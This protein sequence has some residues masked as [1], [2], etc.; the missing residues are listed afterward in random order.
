MAGGCPRRE[1]D[2]PKS[3]ISSAGRQRAKRLNFNLP[4]G[5]VAVQKMWAEK[6]EIGPFKTA[7][8]TAGYE[9]TTGTKAGVWVL[10]DVKS[11]LVLG[12]V[13]RLLKLKRQAV[14]NMM[15]TTDERKP[16]IQNGSNAAH[17]R[18]RA[19][20]VRS[21]QRDR[22]VAGSD[23][24]VVRPDR[25]K[26]IGTKGR[27]NRED[28]RTVID[29]SRNPAAPGPTPA[30]LEQKTGFRYRPID[31]RRAIQRLNRIDFGRIVALTLLY[32]NH[33]PFQHDHEELIQSSPSVLTID[34]CDIWG[35]PVPKAQI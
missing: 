23:A 3:A 28:R 2:K 16:E 5:R 15:E 33:R 19:K 29:N 13:D 22:G 14:R 11:G 34:G 24:T 17:G 21:E 20:I 35:I 6:P 4:A 7:L 32:A 27:S 25:G 18:S 30:R 1:S 9:I 10:R 12:A 31:R 8:S 26:G